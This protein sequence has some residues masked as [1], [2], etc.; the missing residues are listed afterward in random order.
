MKRSTL[1][2]A[3][4]C[5][6]GLGATSSAMAIPYPVQLCAQPLVKDLTPG[7]TT[8]SEFVD[9]WGYSISY[10]PSVDPCT[11]PATSPGP[12]IVVPDGSRGTVYDG[13]EVTLH[14]R[15]PRTTSLVIPGTVKAEGMSPTTFTGPNGLQRVRSFDADAVPGTSVTY[16]WDDLP[17]GSY[18]Y[19]S[20]THSQLQVQMGLY[21]AVTNAEITAVVSP[22]TVTPGEAYTGVPYT[23]EIVLFYSE[24]DRAMHDDV[25]T[26]GGFDYDETDM[27]S[28]FSYAPK[29][30]MIDVE[31]NGSPSVSFDQTAFPPQI[32]I[33][34]DSNPLVRVFNA[35]QRIHI[36]T[37][38]QGGFTVYAEDGKLYPTPHELYAL[39]MPPLK[40]RDAIL[41]PG[42]GPGGGSFKLLDSTMALSNPDELGGVARALATGSE[43]ANGDGNGMVL[44]IVSLSEAGFAPSAPS[45]N[46][47]LAQR[48]QMSVLEGGSIG[49]IL[50]LAMDNDGN[51]SRTVASI[52]SY[53]AHGELVNN[54]R[55]YDYN[56]NGSE[57]EVDSL[58]Y[59]L[60]N[61]AGESSIA[62]IVIDVSPVNDTPVANDDSATAKVGQTIEI[63]ALNNDSDIDSASIRITGV[64]ESGLG[65]ISAQD[66]VIVF[67][68]E[69]EGDEV[70]TYTMADS[71]GGSAQ[72]SLHLSVTPAADAAGDGTF[73]GSATGARSGGDTAVAEPAIPPVARPD[74]YR[75]A[76]GGTLDITEAI[77]GV[78]AND[79]QD[80][81]VTTDLIRYP[82]HGAI[83][84]NKDGTFTYTHN[85]TDDTDDLFA[86]EIYNGA[87]SDKAR[88]DI[89]VYP[90]S[91]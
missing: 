35:G 72:A 1:T 55:D 4:L 83:Q 32:T 56:H 23:H 79:S 88:V 91:R 69:T 85:G 18:L 27:K 38:M 76:V 52:L 73:T 62:G 3:V 77:L 50:A 42:V 6:L 61:A 65:S 82:A 24:I 45:A 74:Y 39:D 84:M 9:M 26:A 28:T 16:T 2:A 41:D 48:D 47:P 63:R 90:A 15:L 17:S 34:A 54:G 29:H 46:A 68:A 37:L 87:G 33:P 12:R 58:V 86:Y 14:N 71:D 53:P 80:A 25:V 10:L 7:N 13:L 70:L 5:I 60:T 78:M 20:G 36:P 67:S 19:H 57:D 8:D 89:K 43:I 66:Q 22:T 11:L 51:A 75:V 21:G 64:D 49:N 81:N 31:T 44:Q 40:T 59:Q 30:F